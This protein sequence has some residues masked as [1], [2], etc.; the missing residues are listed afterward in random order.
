MNGTEEVTGF[1][2]GAIY[3]VLTSGPAA[4]RTIRMRLETLG[5]HD[6]GTGGGGPDYGVVYRHLA[7]V[8]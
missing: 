4:Q 3:E 5:D 1:V 7:L 2:W 8:Q 6:L